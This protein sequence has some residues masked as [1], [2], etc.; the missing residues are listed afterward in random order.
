MKVVIDTNILI[1]AMLRDR[2]PECVILYISES[3]S[4]VW[5]VTPGIMAEYR[6]VMARKKFGFPPDL[7]EKWLGVVNRAALLNDTLATVS[8]PRDPKDA[9]FLSC[10]LAAK[11][12]FLITGDRDLLEFKL[13]GTAI[14]TVAQFI[15]LAMPGIST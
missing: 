13:P 10:A 15:R 6:E 3:E 4:W 14:V 12:D 5:V 7:Q 1:S 9:E 8:L 11:A 2:D